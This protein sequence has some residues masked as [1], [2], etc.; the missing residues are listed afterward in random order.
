M[1]PIQQTPP[2]PT[3]ISPEQ[4]PIPTPVPA[5]TQPYT[6]AAPYQVT[7]SVPGSGLSIAG[8]VI[9]LVAIV[10][11]FF[12]FGLV[13]VLG[14]VLSIIGRIQTKRAGHPSGLALAGIIIS[15]VSGVLTFVAF[16]FIAFGAIQTGAH[17]RELGDGTHD[18]GNMRYTCS[19]NGA[20]S[21]VE[22]I[23]N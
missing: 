6:G 10:S 14:F 16:A 11:N 17:C 20:N 9:S 23:K 19:D 13:A 4:P 21:S 12:T 22:A 3:P 15:V 8:F 7:A 5:Y 2:A 1:D 18:V